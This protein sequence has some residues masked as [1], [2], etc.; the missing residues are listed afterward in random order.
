MVL[1]ADFF[2]LCLH[3]LVFQVD[4]GPDGTVCHTVPMP[5]MIICFS[6]DL[7]P[8][9]Q[10][11]AF[12]VSQEKFREGGTHGAYVV[13]R[14]SLLDYLTTLVG[15]RGEGQNWK[16]LAEVDAVQSTCCQ[17]VRKRYSYRL[18]YFSR[19]CFTCL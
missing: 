15:T 3:W 18:I 5:L 14:L 12:F 13:Y 11:P 7:A 16:T 17:N 1:L 9:E 2:S 19:G 6:C 8:T 4:S 10:W